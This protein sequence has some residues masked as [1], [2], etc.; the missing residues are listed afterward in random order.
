[1]PK[2][3]KKILKR[4][5]RVIRN[6]RDRIKCRVLSQKKIDEMIKLNNIKILDSFEKLKADKKFS[7]GA[8][9]LSTYC[10][11]NCLMCNTKATTREKGEISWETFLKAVDEFHK[12]E[13]KGVCFH[14]INEPLLDKRMIDMLEVLKEKEMGLGLSTNGMLVD[15]FLDQVKET[16]LRN[17][18][19]RFSIDGATKETYEKI[20]VG[21]NFEKLIANLE[22][23][24]EFK[25]KYFKDL[26][27][28]A[29]YVISKDNIN[30]VPL[31]IKK[32][33]K[34]FNGIEFSLIS[35]LTPAE[36]QS[37]YENIYLTKKNY[38]IKPCL[39]LWDNLNVLY[40]GDVSACCRDY[41]GELVVGNIY[42]NTLEEIWN[43]DKMNAL[44]DAHL[45]GSLDSVPPPCK[46]CRGSNY[47]LFT[48]INYL[49]NLTLGGRYTPKKFLELIQKTI[50][51]YNEKAS[52]LHDMAN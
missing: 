5:E 15:K 51:K 42:K 40:N 7:G 12:N 29:N 27:I 38:Q 21:A 26:N 52:S 48:E 34:Y 20:R 22:K 28:S 19:L 30:E 46:I 25:K 32:F 13:I 41:T 4:I 23:T 31:F 33:K 9:E 24:L 1:M 17:F 11:L 47:F 37:Y 16:N 2:G 50:E 14:T 18:C 6:I 49:A 10:N 3:I 8:I 43:N 35:S 39:M 45:N 44:R 36:G